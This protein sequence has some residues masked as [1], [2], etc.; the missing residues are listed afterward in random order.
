MTIDYTAASAGE[1]GEVGMRRE[2]KKPLSNVKS[3][4]HRKGSM[5][6]N[7]TVNSSRRSLLLRYWRRNIQLKYKHLTH[8]V[9][10]YETHLLYPINEY[11]VVIDCC[12]VHVVSFE[13]NIRIYRTEKRSLKWINSS[14]GTPVSISIFKPYFLRSL[15]LKFID[16]RNFPDSFLAGWCAINTILVTN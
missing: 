11:F 3:E 13:F 2:T 9:I 8:V 6:C 16:S 7:I 1:A 4:I 12:Y 5:K 10:K 14:R 15:Y